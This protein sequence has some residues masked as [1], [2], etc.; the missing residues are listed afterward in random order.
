[1][2]SIQAQLFSPEDLLLKQAAANVEGTRLPHS[3][4]ISG[5]R[6]RAVCHTPASRRDWVSEGKP[7]D[8]QQHMS[9]RLWLWREGCTACDDPPGRSLVPRP[10]QSGFRILRGRVDH[11][12]S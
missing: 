9:F 7:I 10:S 12:G 2:T 6:A 5:P 11:T 4:R 3:R 1:L 8:L